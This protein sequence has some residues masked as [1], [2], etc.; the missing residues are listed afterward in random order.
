M[1]KLILKILVLV[2]FT[3]EIRGQDI[4]PPLVKKL[5]IKKSQGRSVIAKTIDSSY[6]HSKYRIDSSFTKHEYYCTVDNGKNFYYTK[7]DYFID[8]EY[9]IYDTVAYWRAGERC[10]KYKPEELMPYFSKINNFFLGSVKDTFYYRPE[11]TITQFG[12]NRVE[13]KLKREMFGDTFNAIANYYFDKN[14]IIKKETN[15][16]NAGRIQKHFTTFTYIKWEKKTNYAT[17]K[18]LK[19]IYLEFSE[20]EKNQ[21]TSSL[22]EVSRLW[23]KNDTLPTYTKEHISNKATRISIDSLIEKHKL[24]I[25]YFSYAGCKPCHILKPHLDTFLSKYESSGL[26][27]VGF[28]NIDSKAYVDSIQTKYPTYYHSKNLDEELEIQLYP[29]LILMDNNHKILAKMRGVNPTS[30]LDLERFIKTS[31]NI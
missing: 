12:E 23:V 15:F 7:G 28:N 3:H 27:I 10:L 24:N 25:L 30:L 11:D 9:L 19:Q 5:Y 22:A 8:H 17:L 20:L 14:G 29:M 1:G 4:L 2:L 18:K 26:N 16:N 31:L 13:F 21:D 6:I